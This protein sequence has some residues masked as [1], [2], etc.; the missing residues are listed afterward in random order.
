ME[1]RK[2][3]IMKNDKSCTFNLAFAIQIL[4]RAIFVNQKINLRKLRTMKINTKTIAGAIAFKLVLSAAILLATFNSSS[5]Q[6]AKLA[7]VNTVELMQQ[8]I[9][10]DSI[11]IKLEQLPTVV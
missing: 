1:E 5:A 11:E 2:N 8:L 10:K 6:D 9:V 3:L 4:K 7:H